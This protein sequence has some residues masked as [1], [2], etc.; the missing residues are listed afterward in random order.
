MQLAVR[1][2]PERNRSHRD[3]AR[4]AGVAQSFTHSILSSAFQ[5]TATSLL[6]RDE[7]LVCLSSTG[8]EAVT[9]I[10]SY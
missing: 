2:L 5:T 4:N 10:T 1:R 7:E 3:E 9:N 8:L 6:K